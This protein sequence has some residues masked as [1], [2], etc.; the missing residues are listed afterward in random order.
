MIEV[1]STT[2]ILP[3]LDR[4]WTSSL[5]LAPSPGRMGIISIHISIVFLPD[6]IPCS[7]RKPRQNSRR[8]QSENVDWLN[9][10]V[11]M[12]R[13]HITVAIVKL[14]S[15]ELE[16]VTRLSC[17]LV[18]SFFSLTR[19]HLLWVFSLHIIIT[20]QCDITTLM[21]LVCLNWGHFELILDQSAIP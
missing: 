18:R 14:T 8:L 19:K 17:S 5:L 2:S 11:L 12:H 7:V 15:R 10:W 20:V 6:T 1:V 3:G 16:H 9:E 13:Q 21:Q 4:K